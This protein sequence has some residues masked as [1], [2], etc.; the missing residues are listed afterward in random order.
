MPSYPVE[1]LWCGNNRAGSGNGWCFPPGVRRRIVSDCEGQSVLHLFGGA[2]TFGTRLDI[3]P[4]TRPD[5]IGDAWLPPFGR[6]SFDVVVLDPPY[7]RFN[8]QIKTAM[9]RAAG[10]I[11]RRR[12]IWFATE[13]VAATGGLRIERGWLVRVGDN[14]HVR[15]L[16][17]FAV[18]ERPGPVNHFVRGPAMKYNKWLAGQLD[19][20][21]ARIERVNGR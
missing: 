10:W 6:E 2:S 1:T 15:C 5:V 21:G 9:F 13:W 14:C 17:Y 12:V 18:A 19:L 7:V 4:I 8:A 11:A 16:Q 3:D 20:P